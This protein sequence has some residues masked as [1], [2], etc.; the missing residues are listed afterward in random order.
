LEQ[1]CV[2]HLC[3]PPKRSRSG[4]LRGTGTPLGNCESWLWII[5]WSARLRKHLRQGLAGISQPARGVKSGG[6]LAG[7]DCSEAS[8]TSLSR[9]PGSTGRAPS[10]SGHLPRKVPSLSP[11][12]RARSSSLSLLLVSVLRSISTAFFPIADHL[13]ESFPQ[14]LCQP[15]GER[16]G[17]PALVCFPGFRGETTMT[18]LR[19]PIGKAK[20]EAQ[21]GVGERR[22]LI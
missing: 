19:Y 17:S 13:P 7:K 12:G 16:S 15:G 22:E 11:E 9:F 10:G 5:G 8:S 4:T 18:D 21:L 6:S 14:A 20:L 1:S 3:P 2:R